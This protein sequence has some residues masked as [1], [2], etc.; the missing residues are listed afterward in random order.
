MDQPEGFND[1]SGRVCRLK[2]PLYGLKQAGRIWN[3]KLNAQLTTLGFTRTNADPCVYYRGFK[4]KTTI[5]TVWVDDIILCG[6]SP[7][8]IDNTVNELQKVF[9]IKDLGEP[10]LLLGIQIIRD[11]KAKTIT[12]SQRNYI[13]TILERFNYSKLNGVS[14]PLDPN[15]ILVKRDDTLTPPDPTTV[16]E[17]QTKLG[18]IMY[19]SIGTMPQLA[20]AVQTLSQFSSNPG[21]EHMSALKRVFRYLATAKEVEVGIVYGGGRQWPTDIIGYSDA[22]WASNPNDRKSI[23]GF[24]FLLGGGAISWSS[25]KQTSVA[26]S[27]TEA[28]Y[29]AAS[30]AARHAI[31]LKRLFEDIGILNSNSITLFIDNQSALSLSGDVM[32]HQ[33]TKHIDVQYHFLRN[34][35]LDGTLSTFYCPTADMV[36]DIMTKALPKP[37]HQKLTEDLG[38]LAA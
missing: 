26:L 10:K 34:A 1:G 13:N 36:A 38:V 24:A 21:P 37:Q 5:L 11:R 20:Y 28:E 12:I 25:K 16:K 2:S 9:E 27:S 3:K 18:S 29:M 19:A 23:S 15:I 35:V 17:Y 33:R 6:D 31:W 30:H 14:M 22:D 8:D 32:F 4:G 7:H